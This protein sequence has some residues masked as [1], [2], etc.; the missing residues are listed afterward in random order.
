MAV[1]QTPLIVAFI[2]G[3]S[4]PDVKIPIFIASDVK[5]LACVKIRKN[6]SNAEIYKKNNV[7]RL[8]NTEKVNFAGYNEL[9]ING[10]EFDQTN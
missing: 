5:L 4:P 2:P 7:I 10:N 1:L 6:K 9:Y 8:I 3:Q